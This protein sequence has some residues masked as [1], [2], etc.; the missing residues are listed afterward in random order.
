MLRPT[1]EMCI[2]YTDW[3]NVDEGVMTIAHHGGE[4]NGGITIGVTR[5]DMTTNPTSAISDA[6]ASSNMQNMKLYG[7]S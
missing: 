5:R 4:W 3:Q 7:L 6:V 1:S 2:Y